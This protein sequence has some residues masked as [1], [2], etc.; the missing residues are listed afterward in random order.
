MANHRVNGMQIGILQTVCDH[1]AGDPATI[2]KRA[3]ELGF[4]SYWLPEHVMLPEGSAQD[5]PRQVA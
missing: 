4:E 5:L 2:A 3:E 1:E